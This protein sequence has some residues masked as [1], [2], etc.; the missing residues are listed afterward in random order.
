MLSCLLG[1]SLQPWLL[2]AQLH[3]DC[4]AQKMNYSWMAVE[5]CSEIYGLIMALVQSEVEVVMTSCMRY[6]TCKSTSN[7]CCC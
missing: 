3:C 1:Q 4:Q 7:C 5:A 2:H 6:A